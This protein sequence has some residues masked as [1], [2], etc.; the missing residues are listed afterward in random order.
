MD[1]RG[2]LAEPLK[3][4]RNA[5]VRSSNFSSDFN[6]TAC[7]RALSHLRPI[8]DLHIPRGAGAAAAFAVFLIAG[9]Y[10]AVY[11]GH[12]NAVTTQLRDARDA[13]ANAAGFRIA[14]VAIGGPKE[15]TREEVLAAAGVTGKSSLLF[16]DAEAARVRLKSNPWIAEATILKLYPDRLHLAVTERQAFAMW[17]KDS[18]ITVIASDGTIVQPFVEPRFANLPLVVGV[19]AEKAASEFLAV[20]DRF[21][22]IRDQ[23]RAYVL[24]AE[25]RWNL[26]LKNGIDIRLPEFEPERALETLVELDR[27]KKLL[28]RDIAVVD[29]RFAGRVTARLSE[30]AAAS[31]QEAMKDKKVRRKGGDA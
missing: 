7:G 5:R 4:S 21:P 19:G 24:V 6:A 28:S 10:G 23:V 14:S 20:T 17:Q 15:V 1:D 11:G 8:L 22:T 13:A 2:R 26:R 9:A 18:R 29:L 12:V 27:D 25:R 30:A 3:R 31:R 16:L